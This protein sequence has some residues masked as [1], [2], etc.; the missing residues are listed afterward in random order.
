MLNRS[1]AGRD[2]VQ[3][4]HLGPESL[5]GHERLVVLAHSRA[6]L[7][8]AP[9]RCADDP[10]GHSGRGAQPRLEELPA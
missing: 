6:A 4:R 8:L 7:R 5:A 3:P 9:E 1:A 10:D 2:L